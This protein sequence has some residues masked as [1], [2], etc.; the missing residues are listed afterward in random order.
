MSAPEPSHSRTSSRL[1]GQNPEFGPL[2]VN[3][4]MYPS[5]SAFRQSRRTDAEETEEEEFS[6]REQDPLSEVEDD[7]DPANAEATPTQDPKGKRP[8]VVI[9]RPTPMKRIPIPETTEDTEEREAHALIDSMFS[10]C[11]FHKPNG[12]RFE[13]TPQGLSALAK[14]ITKL[15]QE[16]PKK[17]IPGQ[18]PVTPQKPTQRVPTPVIP[19]TPPQKARKDPSML[20]K[21][22]SRIGQELKDTFLPTMFHPGPSK[23]PCTCLSL[24]P[25]QRV[26][27]QR[28][29]SVPLSQAKPL[30]KPAFHWV[31]PRPAPRAPSPPDTA[32]VPPYQQILQQPPPP[33]EAAPPPSTPKTPKQVRMSAPPESDPGDSDGCSS[34]S[35]EGDTNNDSGKAS[36]RGRR[37]RSVGS[38]TSSVFGNSRLK[39]PKLEKNSGSGKWKEAAIFDNW[40]ND[41]MDILEVGELD[42]EARQA[43]IWL[44]WNL[45]GEAK[46]LHASYRINPETKNNTVP[47]FL[48]VLRK[49]CI[50]FI[51]DDKLWTEFQAI[52]QIQNGRSKPIQQVAN[53]IKQLQILLPKISNWQCYNQLLEVMDPALLQEVRANINDEKEWD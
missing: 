21:I 52:R 13:P 29:T 41:A 45:E 33:P 50:P 38:T 51:S 8:E 24:P 43:M 14:K 15:A 11:H 28:P 44:G 32:W 46:I 7:P 37:S 47:E 31:V 10:I 20:S 36:S 12:P 39:A 17:P 3:P 2:R 9:Q 5:R 49:F 25:H 22:G 4:P 30:N 53:R 42:P 48:K 1:T 26:P 6:K 18:F 40:A 23:Q 27:H 34:S 19:P 16:L 35:S